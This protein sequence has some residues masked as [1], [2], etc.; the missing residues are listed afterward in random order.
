[1]TTNIPALDAWARGH[2]K[3]SLF[4]GFDAERVA[5]PE[6]AYLDTLYIRMRNGEK[7]IFTETLY[8]DKLNQQRLKKFARAFPVSVRR[9][10]GKS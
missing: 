1:M 3:S 7:G 8:R 2:L 9:G 4:F 5:Y 10:I 6:K